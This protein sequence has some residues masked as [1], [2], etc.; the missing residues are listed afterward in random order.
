MS[1][2]LETASF[3]DLASEQQLVT[4]VATSLS[5]SKAIT[6]TEEF[7]LAEDDDSQEETEDESDEVKL[8]YLYLV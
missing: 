7:L 1:S 3:T 8:V 4:M 2:I 6:S 5:P